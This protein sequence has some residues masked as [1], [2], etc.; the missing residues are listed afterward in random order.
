MIK[1]ILF[2]IALAALPLSA[3]AA[4]ELQWNLG[5]TGSTVYAVIW[6]E[7]GQAWNGSAFATYT[8]T[9]SSF[10]VSMTEIGTTGYFTGTFPGSA[11]ARRWEYFLQAGG[12]PSQ[13]DDISIG[14]GS[15][16]WTGAVLTS[17]GPADTR[18]L[19]PTQFTWKL[20]RRSDG[21]IVSINTLRIAPGESI[22]SGYDCDMQ[23]ITP[24]GT[25]LGSMT[26][27]TP[28]SGS[29]SATKLGVDP[30]VAK[31]EVTAASN[32]TD[33][34]EAYIRCTVTNSHGAGPVTLLGHVIVVA[35][36]TVP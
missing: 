11:G 3:Q 1:R 36:P 23:L 26:T 21:T 16:Y 12:S 28:A 18:D 25:V 20:S 4:N 32:A 2:A 30:K 8:S 31:V 35:E 14:M 13:A 10:A 34:T 17:G 6:N 33:G 24:G 15:G 22:R 7:S 5:Q 19:E 27:P 9:R 29:I